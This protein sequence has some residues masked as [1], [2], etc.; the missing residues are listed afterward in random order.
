MGERVRVSEMDVDNDLDI[1]R[2][3]LNTGLVWVFGETAERSEKRG[4]EGT[5]LTTSRS[6]LKEETKGVEHGGS[7][8]LDPEPICPHQSP[9]LRPL[10][11]SPCSSR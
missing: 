6:F 8:P 3:R 1:Y 9:F 2:Q 10:F 7:S 5:P 4:K 11:S